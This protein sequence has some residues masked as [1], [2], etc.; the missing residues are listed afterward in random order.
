MQGRT[1]KNTIISATESVI[2][3]S[4]T[5]AQRP[6]SPTIGATR[7]N[8]TSGNLEVFNGTSFDTIALEGLTNVVVDSFVGDASTTVFGSLTNQI[9]NETD[10]LVFVG[11]VFQ[12][13]ETNYTVDGSYDITF[14]TAPPAG[15]PINIVQNL[16]TTTV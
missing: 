16:N 5:S 10:V 2:I 8:T 3:P 11:G 15:V 7:F 6:S 4:G 1:L 13:P 14:T 9:D 12:I